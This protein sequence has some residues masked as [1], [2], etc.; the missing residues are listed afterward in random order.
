[1]AALVYKVNKANHNILGKHTTPD[2]IAKIVAELYLGNEDKRIQPHNR[3]QIEK[4]IGYGHD[5]VW[6]FMNKAVE[7]GLLEKKDGKFVK[8]EITAEQ[9]FQ[10]FTKEHPILNDL[11]IAEWYEG[12]SRKNHGKGIK[13]LKS[14]VVQIETVCNTCHV[15]PTQLVAS[16]KNAVEIKNNFLKAYKEHRV[17]TV[18]P[19]VKLKYKAKLEMIDYVYSYAIASVCEKFGV[20]WE[21]GTDEMSRQV[22][23]HGKYAH[24]RLTDEELQKADRYIKDRFGI[25]SNLFRLFWFGIE[26]CARHDASFTAELDYTK[27]TSHKNGKTTFHLS[28]FESKTS[29]IDDGIFIKR[30][31]K[32]DLQ[33]SLQYLKER[34][35]TR[36]YEITDLTKNK[37]IEQIKLQMLDLYVYLGK[38]TDIGKLYELRKQGYYDTG[39]Y[40][41]DHWYHTLRHVGAQYHLSKTN[42]NY[43]YVALIGGW[44]TIDELKKSYGK[45]PPEVL[46]ALLEEFD[47]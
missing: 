10:K 36:I 17:V 1:M 14:M 45:M 44:H 35:G 26:T 39:N 25:D 3:R 37:T 21:K 13:K 42:Y 47:Y 15:T 24:I 11:I 18:R 6:R 8:P 20:T 27:H 12:K 33:Q 31:S 29:H 32:P 30:I 34:G 46:D 7:L 23:S 4:A 22:P 2:E 16:K 5:S 43:G 41:F 28:V 38:I 9:E 40:W 19:R